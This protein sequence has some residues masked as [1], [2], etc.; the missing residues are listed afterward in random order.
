MTD[1]G[2]DPKPPG[3]AQGGERTSVETP[4]Y[5]SQGVLLQPPPMWTRILIWTLGMGTVLLL[6][7]SWFTRIDETVSMDGAI[8]T[9][10]PEAKVTSANEGQIEAVLIHPDQVVRKGD[11][12]FRLSTQD[13]DVTIAGLKAKLVELEHQRQVER[14]LYGARVG[15][16]EIQAKL[17]RTVLERLTQLASTGAAQEVQ[18]IERQSTLQETLN[19][20][21]VAKKELAKA[22][23]ILLIQQLETNNAIRELVGKRS[24]NRVLAPVSGTVHTMRFN[25]AGER[26]NAGDEMAT[27]VPRLQLLAAVSVPSRVSAPVKKGNSAKLSVDAFP[28]NDFG[29]LSGTIVSISPNTSISQEV[30]KDSNYRAMIAIDRALVSSRFPIDQLRPGMGVKAKVKL[31]ERAVITLVFDF[32]DKAIAPLTQSK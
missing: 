2:P 17:H 28:S 30:G 29:E 11:L 21:E 6:V 25:A 27:I 26:V 18:V 8:E 22:D 10:S 9:A 3:P 1:P 5:A 15:Q 14:N 24:E 20:M 13:V 7:W 19:A 32:L 23:N 4:A 12:L 16:L 31:R